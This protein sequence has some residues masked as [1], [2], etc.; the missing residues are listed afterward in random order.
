MHVPVAGLLH[1]PDT[2]LRHGLCFEASPAAHQECLRSKTAL[3][4]TVTLQD[5]VCPRARCEL[6]CS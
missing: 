3:E 5:T 6:L 2:L 1:V 4:S